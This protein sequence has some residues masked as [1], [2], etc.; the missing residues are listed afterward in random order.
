MGVPPVHGGAVLN[1]L[2]QFVLYRA[3]LARD[4]DDDGIGRDAGVGQDDGS[5]ADE[6]VVCDFSVF[7]EDGVDAN[8]DV[9]AHAVAVKNGAVGDDNVVA[10]FKVVV[11]VQDAVVLDIGVAPD[12]DAAVVAAEDGT[13][14]DAGVFA[15]CDVTDDVGGLADEGARVY[16]WSESVKASNH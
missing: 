8:H 4:A 1:D 7:E 11:G 9:V 2:E 10:D 15:Y 5:G 6:A 16:G 14:P 3:D 12:C 13:G